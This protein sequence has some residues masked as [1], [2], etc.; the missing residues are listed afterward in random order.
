MMLHS[1]REV[2]QSTAVD[3]EWYEGDAILTLSG[4]VRHC[5][6]TVGAFKVGIELQFPSSES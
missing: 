3:I 2:A 4:K 1:H 5:T 6:G